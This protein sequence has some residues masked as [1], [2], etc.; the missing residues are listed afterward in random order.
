MEAVTSFKDVIG[1]SI[2]HKGKE[3]FIHEMPYEA[4]NEDALYE[5]YAYTKNDESI[6]VTWFDDDANEF[7][8]SY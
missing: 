6:L 8:L 1:K 5:V 4:N 7:W 2:K 3:Y